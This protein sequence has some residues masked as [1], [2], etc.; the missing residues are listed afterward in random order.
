M[1]PCDNWTLVPDSR[2]HVVHRACVCVCAGSEAPVVVD[3]GVAA[4]SI[5][6]MPDGVSA[7]VGDVTGACATRLMRTCA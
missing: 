1:L 2:A 4:T 5:D 3:I 7:V 6:A